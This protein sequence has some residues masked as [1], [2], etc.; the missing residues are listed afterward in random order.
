M[1]SSSSKLMPAAT[2][3]MPRQPSQSPMNPLRVRDSR[4]PINSPLMMAPMTFP[5]R[6]GAA[7]CAA[8]GKISCGMTEDAPMHTLAIS[9]QRR[10]GE[11]AANISET[12]AIPAIQTIWPRR[13][14]LSPSGTKNSNPSA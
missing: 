12:T 3:N 1:T 5:V 10:L 6:E 9:R 13:S 14:T 4:I 2:P 7:R 11:S 8:I